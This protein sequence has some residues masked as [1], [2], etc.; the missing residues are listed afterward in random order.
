ME[1][2]EVLL[3]WDLGELKDRFSKGF[4]SEEFFQ[5]GNCM[6]DSAAKIHHSI[7]SNKLLN[8]I[9]GFFWQVCCVKNF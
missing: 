1:I 2:K 8:L 4:E 5:K 9:E 6:K 7:R 3:I